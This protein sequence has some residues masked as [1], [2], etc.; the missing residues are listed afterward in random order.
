MKSYINCVKR[1]QKMQR[2]LMVFND[3]KCGSYG[4][5]I[6]IAVGLEYINVEVKEYRES[7]MVVRRSFPL[8]PKKGNAF[9]KM[10]AKG[11]CDEIEEYIND[12]INSK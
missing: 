6:C 8:I 12:K 1:L 9:D 10:F 4:I 3:T 11:V 7:A 5:D 2:R